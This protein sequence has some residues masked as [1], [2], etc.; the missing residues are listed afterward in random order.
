MKTTDQRQCLELMAVP[1]LHFGTL[2]F[3]LYVTPTFQE[4]VVGCQREPHQCHQGLYEDIKKHSFS[5]FLVYLKQTESGCPNSTR[6]EIS[7]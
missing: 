1:K 3:L 2:N 7:E 4:L 5:I 6:N